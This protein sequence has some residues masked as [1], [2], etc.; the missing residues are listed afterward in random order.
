MPKRCDCIY[1]RTHISLS[2]IATKDAFGN[3]SRCRDSAF[4][5]HVVAPVTGDNGADDYRM[6][7]SYI[8]H[9]SH[10]QQQLLIIT[11]AIYI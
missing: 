4:A 2:K 3:D 7:E 1:N 9:Q 10:Q 6:Q 8:I 11:H 5:A